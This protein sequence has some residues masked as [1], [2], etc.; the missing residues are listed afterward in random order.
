MN[1]NKNKEFY[2]CSIH[3][4]SITQ[5]ILDTFLVFDEDNKDHKLSKK[6]LAEKLDYA[7]FQKKNKGK[8]IFVNYV[9]Y[10][11]SISIDNSMMNEFFAELISTN[12]C[13]Y[14]ASADIDMNAKEEI[15]K[16][17]QIQK[18]KKGGISF[19]KAAIIALLSVF[20]GAGGTLVLCKKFLSSPTTET[21]VTQEVKNNGMIIPQQAEINEDAQ[22]ITVSIDRSYLAVPTEDLQ[23]R[24]EVIDGVANITLPE[25]DKTDFFNHVPGYTWGFTTD[26][27]GTKIQYYGGKTYPFEV[28]TKLY[29]VLVKYA[30]GA[31]TKENPYLIDYYD[32]LELMAEEKTRGYFK[33]IAD[34]TYPDY[35]NHTAIDTVNELKGSPDSEYFEYDG[36]GYTISNINSSLFG[37]VSGAVI[38]N[39][40]ILD[41]RISTSEYK[42]IGFI[43]SKALNYS[44]T[45]NDGTKYTTGE[46][47]IQHCSVA[48]S[49]IIT[50]GFDSEAP[51]EE[52]TTESVEVVAPDVIE[53]DEDGNIIEEV[54]VVTPTKTAEYC[55]G[56]I[57][58]IGGTIKDCYVT[59]F[60]VECNLSD[61]W[62]YVGGISGKPESVTNSVVY[63]FTTNGNIF[64]AGGIVG[65]A[66]GTRMYDTLGNQLP[67]ACGGNIKGCVS[68]YI[69]LAAEVACGGI[70][71]E[72][73]SNNKNAVISN[74]YAKSLSF[75]CGVFDEENIALELGSTGSLIG[76]DG[77]E[78]YGHTTTNNVV[79]DAFEAISKKTRS[80]Y[81]DTLKLAPDYAFY[82]ENILTVL[83]TNSVDKENP[84]EIYTGNFKFGDMFGDENGSLAYP[85]TIEDLFE[86]TIMEE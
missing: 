8:Q 31:G 85:A 84:K 80:K 33:Q 83:N 72:A 3:A 4:E 38:K 30:G 15:K 61:Y 45:A 49:A 74:C 69:S 48:R 11:T 23:L 43:V 41:S 25:F 35:A 75:Y 7:D 26:P 52:P 1:L 54:E 59:D 60:D 13:E 58:G 37:T 34:I 70:A 32:Q 53:Y 14:I 50:E 27:N 79:S 55:I 62:L 73:T 56:A 17:K 19:V 67:Q 51:T 63:G 5:E 78:L 47:L 39:V 24:A 12:Q 20:I 9:T 81:D 16:A 6:M 46:T 22:Q 18:K 28:D 65:S 44:Y 2:F 86:V 42:D 66:S 68:R 76:A 77:N 10:K 82:Q 29:R 71:G 57:S 21:V 64:N 40:T 36:N